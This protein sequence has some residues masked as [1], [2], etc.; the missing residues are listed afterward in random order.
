[1]HYCKAWRFSRDMLHNYLMLLT[2]L[3]FY[4]FVI[5][6]P[7][8]CTL[9]SYMSRERDRISLAPSRPASVIGYSAPGTLRSIKSEVMTRPAIHMNGKPSTSPEVARNDMG[10]VS[11]VSTTPPVNGIIKGEVYV[12]RPPSLY[13]ERP[14]DIQNLEVLN[15]DRRG[16]SS[17]SN[18]TSPVRSKD[19]LQ[20]DIKRSVSSASRQN[21]KEQ[22]RRKHLPPIFI[23]EGYEPGDK[24]PSTEETQ[25]KT[26]CKEGVVSSIGVN[27]LNYYM[28]SDYHPDCLTD[29][30]PRNRM[31]HAPSTETEGGESYKS[32]DI[33]DALNT[34]I[35]HSHGVPLANISDRTSS[36]RC[37]KESP[38]I[39]RR[40]RD[41]NKGVYSTFDDLSQ[42]CMKQEHEIEFNNES[43][44]MEDMR[45]NYQSIPIQTNYMGINDNSL[46]YCA[47][48]SQFSSFKPDGSGL[49]HTL[50]KHSQS[51]PEIRNK[52]NTPSVSRQPETE[53]PVE[54]STTM[55]V[56]REIHA[57][58]Q[59]RF[60]QTN[61]SKPEVDNTSFQQ[62]RLE[63]FRQKQN[64]GNGAFSS[65]LTNKA[66]NTIDDENA[67]S[68]S[69]SSVTLSP[70][71][72]GT[73]RRPWMDEVE[74]DEHSQ[75]GEPLV[76]DS[77]TETFR[78]PQDGADHRLALNYDTRYAASLH[79]DLSTPVSSIFDEETDRGF[80][81][82]L[83]MHI[84]PGATVY[85]GVGLCFES[86]KEE[87]EDLVSSSGSN[88]FLS[89]GNNDDEFRTQVVISRSSRSNS[90]T[91]SSTSI[92]ENPFSTS[93]RG[94]TV[95]PSIEFSEQTP[96][97]TPTIVTTD[98]DFDFADSGFTS[99][100]DRGNGS[101]S[102]GQHEISYQGRVSPW[103]DE[104]KKPDSIEMSFESNFISKPD[105]HV[106]STPVVAK[107]YDKQTETSPSAQSKVIDSPVVKPKT[108]PVF[109]GKKPFHKAVEAIKNNN[110]PTPVRVRSFER[111]SSPVPERKLP[112]RG[113]SFETDRSDVKPAYF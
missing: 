54:Y 92:G 78:E 80:E 19:T 82:A 52:V 98:A 34:S 70:Y 86:I 14:V 66:D 102:S 17:D 13:D 65:V 37:Y 103:P 23:N 1:M 28:S 101:D 105:R 97:T 41:V 48:Q 68:G 26:V 90:R 113:H 21:W 91:S 40:R 107:S 60:Q 50:P 27:S 63:N 79:S 43:I 42:M 62:S 81:D 12:E 30:L 89:N 45:D 112:K 47:Q 77:D 53:V 29:S 96:V 24:S 87:P 94:V 88:P 67:S 108:S 44:P 33:D 111:Y 10:V 7:T 84:N 110:R 9:Q 5:S 18:A 6:E 71:K 99:G 39:P 72:E 32:D 73:R 69:N 85:G 36:F 58:A 16:Y 104:Y 76:A 15:V 61:S 8:A 56:P 25:V 20:V 93:P 2:K 35:Q 22:M 83:E 51:R 3:K 46:Q 64:G 57:L 59:M 74:L 109:E 49:R 95:N 38:D 11:T 55:C 100:L 31:R 4:V 75:I 106:T